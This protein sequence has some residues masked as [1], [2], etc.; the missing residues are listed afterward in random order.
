M[1]ISRGYT[2][3][4][5]LAGPYAIKIAR[6][7]LLKTVYLGVRS[8][9]R[10]FRNKTQWRSSDRRYPDGLLKTAWEHTFIGL[11][12]NRAEHA[13]WANTRDQRCV[14]IERRCF[15]GLVLWQSKAEP[16]SESE[17]LASPLATLY[18]TDGELCRVEQYGRFAGECRIIDYAQW[19]GFDFGQRK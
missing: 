19:G 3:I 7:R 12:A 9:V 6:I 14:P 10:V 15:W 4:V 13:Y 5:I 17:I 16:V 11:Y 8:V 1:Q 2:R 18:R